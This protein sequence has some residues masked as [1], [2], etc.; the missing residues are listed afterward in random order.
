M[1][2]TVSP[3]DEGFEHIS[4]CEDCDFEVQ[5]RFDRRTSVNTLL[6]K[7]LSDMVFQILQLLQFAMLCSK[8]PIF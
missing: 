4:D 3:L 6:L 7:W 2:H 5:L 1:K 8:T